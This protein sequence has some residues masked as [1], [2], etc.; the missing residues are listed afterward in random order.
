M[1]RAAP[2]AA[3]VV[4]R[5]KDGAMALREIKLNSLRN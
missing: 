5:V 2:T 4:I 1:C 3:A